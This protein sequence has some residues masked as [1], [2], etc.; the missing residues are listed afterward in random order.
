MKPKN[1][2]IG[3]LGLIVGYFFITDHLTTLTHKILFSSSGDEFQTEEIETWFNLDIKH[4]VIVFLHIQKT[5]GKMLDSILVYSLSLVTP[6][7]CVRRRSSGCRCRSSNGHIWLYSRL[8]T[9]WICGV[10]A[11]WT[12]L[13]E[14]VPRTLNILEGN[15]QMIQSNR[16]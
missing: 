13:H 12:E 11:D 6:C 2:I 1:L 10:H 7:H 9:N 16:R 15:F 3:I 5:G 14:C 4:D 8:S